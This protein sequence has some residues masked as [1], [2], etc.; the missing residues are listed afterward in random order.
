MSSEE[1]R[2]VVESLFQLRFQLWY[3]HFVNGHAWCKECIHQKGE[4]TAGQATTVD[5]CRA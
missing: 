1:G 2:R 5:T 3:C 4:K